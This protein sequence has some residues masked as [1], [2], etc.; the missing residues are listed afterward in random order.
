MKTTII[1]SA[2]KK[3]LKEL[4]SNPNNIT[5]IKKGDIS[6]NSIEIE[7]KEPISFSSYVYYDNET[8]R[9]KDLT[10]LETLLK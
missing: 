6:G 9:D 8:N 7:F 5:T 4:I 1:N 10:E 2:L 3:D